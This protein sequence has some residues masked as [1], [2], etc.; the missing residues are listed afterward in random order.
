MGEHEEI[1]DDIEDIAESKLKDI[2]KMW[3][4]QFYINFN[5]LAK[6]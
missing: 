3:V 1:E 2:F 5:Y 6:Y 4:M